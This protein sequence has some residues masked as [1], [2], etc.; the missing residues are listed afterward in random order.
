MPL[1]RM[2]IC[3]PIKKGESNMAS[4]TTNPLHK[5]CSKGTK[6]YQ[7]AATFE[8]F[9]QAPATMLQVAK[10]TDIE[11]ANI[12]RYVAR[13]RKQGSIAVVKKGYCP[14]T[15]HMAGYY[16]TNPALFPPIPKQLNLFT[17][18]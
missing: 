8:T 7:L 5:G 3:Q 11:R 1:K 6:V 16:T 2:P 12:C 10:L 13:F 15:Q 17:N 14:I 9:F 4:H 18:E